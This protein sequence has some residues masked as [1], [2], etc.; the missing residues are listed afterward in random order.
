MIAIDLEKHLSEIVEFSQDLANEHPADCSCGLEN[1]ELKQL[2]ITGIWHLFYMTIVTS[3][4]SLAG[5]RNQTGISSNF[6]AGEATGNLT[7]IFNFE[8][9]I[10]SACVRN[11][12]KLIKEQKGFVIGL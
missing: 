11:Y 10:A 12:I 5:S 4:I 9:H 8:P 7:K 2:Y 3:N 1:D 6:N